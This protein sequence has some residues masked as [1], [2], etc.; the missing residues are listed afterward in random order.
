[1]KADR[2]RLIIV[3]RVRIIPPKLHRLPELHRLIDHIRPWYS[4][5]T[6]DGLRQIVAAAEARLFA[7]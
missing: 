2:L 6:I 1:V 7:A 5:D 3:R 4:G